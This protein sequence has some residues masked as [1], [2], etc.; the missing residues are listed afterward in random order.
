[1]PQAMSQPVSDPLGVRHIRL[2]PRHRFDLLRIDDQ[3][4]TSAREGREACFWALD[5][6]YCSG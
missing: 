4:V 1:M 6:S 3:H 5:E 2:S